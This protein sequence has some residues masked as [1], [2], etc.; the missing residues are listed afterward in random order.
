VR[1]ANLGYAVT[2]HRAQGVTV[3]TAHCVVTPA[4]TRENLY[5]A[6]TRGRFRNHAYVATDR[7]DGSH[8]VP[9]PSD[10]V[11]ATAATVLAGVLANSGA[12]LSAHQTQVAEHEWWNSI[13]QLAAER[14][15]VESVALAD[16]WA[17][18][19]RAS[20]LSEQQVGEVLESDAFGPLCAELRLADANHRPVAAMLSAVVRGGNLGTAADVA[21]VLHHRMSTLNDQQSTGSTRSRQAPRMILGFIPEA[22][23]DCSPRMRSMLDEYKTAL[24]TRARDLAHRALTERAPWLAELGVRPAEGPARARWDRALLAAAAYREL[25]TVT[26]PTMLGSSTT[27][28]QREDAARIRTLVNQV[29]PSRART[30]TPVSAPTHARAQG[31]SL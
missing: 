22:E 4:T 7:P 27:A 26:G 10:D 21:S 24:D 16:H 3:D 6:M 9:H 12:E 19:I 14:E 8:D 30:Q 11:D 20:G 23:G 5:V 25:H 2:A 15:T 18:M 28:R 1:L 29:H 31:P 13:R 17:G